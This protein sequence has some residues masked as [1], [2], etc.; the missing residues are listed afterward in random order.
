ME[1]GGLWSKGGQRPA[2]SATDKLWDLEQAPDPLWA[3]VSPFINEE[4][5]LDHL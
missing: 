3:S 2:A 1:M 5:G 4:F